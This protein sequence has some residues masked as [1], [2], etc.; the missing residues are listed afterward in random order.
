MYSQRHTSRCILKSAQNQLSPRSASST[1]SRDSIFVSQLHIT[2]HISPLHKIAFIYILID[3]F[4][5]SFLF[6]YIS[7]EIWMVKFLAKKEER[8]LCVIYWDDV[9]YI[10]FNT[11]SSPATCVISVLMYP[12]MRAGQSIRLQQQTHSALT[13]QRKKKRRRRFCV[14]KCPIS[15]SST[16]QRAYLFLSSVGY[17]AAISYIIIS[18]IPFF[19]YL[20][21]S[22]SEPYKNQTNAYTVI[23][24]E[25]F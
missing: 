4:I 10:L 7:Y 24:T 25:I 12:Y 3:C 2:I 8:S 21:F 19:F 17:Q 16:P 1:E 11:M 9:G 6:F 15:R 18:F 5:V 20:I 22:S 23:S 14:G 13:Q